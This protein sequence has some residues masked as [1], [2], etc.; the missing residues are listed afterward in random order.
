MKKLVLTA[1]LALVGFAGTA[2]A[3]TVNSKIDL[4]GIPKYVT[5]TGL[6]SKVSNALL[7]LN[8]DIANRD[9][10]DSEAFYRVRWLDESGD[11][12][13]E[14]EA[15]K[16]VLLHGNQKIHLRLIAPNDKARD[17]R[18]ELTQVSIL[19]FPF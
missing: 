9:T 13:A 2:G 1:L 18:I 17:F 15:W 7:V 11:V 4:F 5:V 3:E 14:E 10:G 16:P 6:S 12:V 19:P 8:L